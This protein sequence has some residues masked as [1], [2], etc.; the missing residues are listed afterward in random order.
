MD[1]RLFYPLIDAVTP[2]VMFVQF[3][4]LSAFC[5]IPKKFR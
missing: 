2:G 5:I 3:C 4:L 1:L